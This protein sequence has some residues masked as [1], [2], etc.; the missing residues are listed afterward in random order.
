[1]PR[2]GSGRGPGRPWTPTTSGWTAPATGRSRP[3]SPRPGRS[4]TPRTTTSSTWPRT[5]TATAA[6]EEQESAAHEPELRQRP[7][8]PAA[9]RRDH[10]GEPGVHRRPLPRPDLPGI[11]APEPALHFR[12]V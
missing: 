6:S 9:H 12:R 4:T 5:R 1:G 7:V 11:P 3:R 8:D 2:G 10:R